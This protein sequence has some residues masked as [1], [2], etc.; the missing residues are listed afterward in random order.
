MSGRGWRAS[1]TN[2]VAAV[3]VAVLLSLLATGTW[4]GWSA[5]LL[6]LLAEGQYS[7]LCTE[8]GEGAA[9]P[10]EPDDAGSGAS[11]CAAQTE[12]LNLVFTLGAASFSLLALPV[13]AMRDAL[14]PRKLALVGGVLYAAASLLLGVA[15]SRTFDAFYLA[16]VLSAAAGAAVFFPAISLAPLFPSRAG[17]V[18]SI[19]NTAFDAS[20]GVF[21]GVRA[22]VFAGVGTRLEVFVALAIGAGT[23]VAVLVFIWPEPP[24]EAS[25]AVLVEAEEDD[26]LV[27]HASDE[28]G[29]SGDA[30]VG[31]SK[32][33][34][35]ESIDASE[36]ILDME[37]SDG[38]AVVCE[39]RPVQPLRDSSLRQILV[40]FAQEPVMRYFL[41][42][43]CVQML[44]M[45]T[46]IGTMVPQLY[47]RFPPDTV[48][49]LVL[50]FNIT[51][52]AGLLFAPL[53]G[54]LIDTFRYVRL[55]WLL[56][57]LLLLYPALHLIDSV[58]LLVF[59]FA[60]FTFARALLYSLLTTFVMRAYGMENFGKLWG[61]SQLLSGVL[62]LF[63]YGL[64][65]AAEGGGLGW[66]F[67]SALHIV[68]AVCC[69]AYPFRLQR[70]IARW[71]RLVDPK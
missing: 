30:D 3:A 36:D 65:A 17:T 47:S 31:T 55:L 42:F 35:S 63:Q 12:R 61:S 70:D 15:D 10:I 29:I 14:G 37:T 49:T 57:S 62:G 18:V 6:V 40:P 53:V 33:D 44:F 38:S 34:T 20:V 54:W 26:S 43:M 56:T 67:V 39:S 41:V 64:T 27:L 46:L 58:V 8:S 52:P 60:I 69:F 71:E 25:F 28:E 7:E 51:L 13:G 5:L 2:R 4:F 16:A 59:N 21:L 23:L 68:V 66:N 24:V 45:N 1:L 48:S 22:L 50:A 11:V 32:P 9:P 19:V